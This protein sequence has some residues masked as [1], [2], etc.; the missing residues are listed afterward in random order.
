MTDF[1]K[2]NEICNLVKKANMYDE[3]GNTAAANEVDAL[4]KN[5]IDAWDLDK[6]A[7]PVV[8]PAMQKD[9]EGIV[10]MLNKIKELREELLEFG[11]GYLDKLK[12]MLATPDLDP[13]QKAYIEQLQAQVSSA[14]T[15]KTVAASLNK[16]A[17]PEWLKKPTC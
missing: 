7:A 14:L 3:L 2:E 15:G 4:I 16:T 5:L 1:L 12:R 6:T 8:D 17:E 10:A 9:L 11:P 13:Q